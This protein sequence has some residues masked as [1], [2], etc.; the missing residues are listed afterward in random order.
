MSAGKTATATGSVSFG[1]ARAPGLFSPGP[2][3]ETRPPW[4]RQARSWVRLA[5]WR[6]NR[7]LPSPKAGGH[8][9]FAHRWDIH[10]QQRVAWSVPEVVE[11]VDDLPGL[12]AGGV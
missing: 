8:V 4:P 10:H 6:L 9:R 5:A 3:P 12:G 11:G 2:C 1:P 7:G